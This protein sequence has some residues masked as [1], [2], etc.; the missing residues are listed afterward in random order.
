MRARVVV[1][2]GELSTD[3]ND[4]ED[5]D[6]HHYQQ[7]TLSRHGSSTTPACEVRSSDRMK[8]R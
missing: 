4:R 2:G 5:D 8:F 6:D 1:T 7:H 3:R